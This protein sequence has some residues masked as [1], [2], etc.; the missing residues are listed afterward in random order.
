MFVIR[1]QQFI[2]VKRT[3]GSIVVPDNFSLWSFS[4]CDTERWSELGQLL[5]IALVCVLGDL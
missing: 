4:V 2:V 5:G 1:K 3:G